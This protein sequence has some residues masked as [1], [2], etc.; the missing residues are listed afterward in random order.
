[1][2]VD[3]KHRYPDKTEK[4]NWDIYDDFKLK[5]KKFGLHGLYKTISA[6]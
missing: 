3:P 1:M 5:K 4:A 6:L 2:P